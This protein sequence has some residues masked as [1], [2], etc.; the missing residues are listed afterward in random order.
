M[1]TCRTAFIINIAALDEKQVFEVE[2]QIGVLAGVTD[3]YLYYGMK[4]RSTHGNFSLNDALNETLSIIYDK[5]DLLKKL[6]TIYNISYMVDVHFSDIEEE[7]YNNTS[8]IV[9]EKIQRF[10]KEI[11]AYYNLQNGYFEEEA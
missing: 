10:I 7:I 2:N 4:K 5:Q 1:P 9:D 3:N 8:F 6:T 11:N